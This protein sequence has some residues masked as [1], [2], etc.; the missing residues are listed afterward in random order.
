MGGC[1]R[2][3]VNDAEP[4][5][6]CFINRFRF[7]VASSAAV[8]VLSCGRGG[9][10][11]PEDVP[12][13]AVI[14]ENPHFQRGI[15][16]FPI[17]NPLSARPNQTTN[18]DRMLSTGAEWVALGAVWYQDNYK[19]TLIAPD[20]R[21]TASD[22][23]VREV[24]RY[25]HGKGAKVMLKPCVNSKD[26]TWRA[27]FE[28][29]SVDAWFNSYRRFINHYADIA[30]EENVEMLCVGVEYKWSDADMYDRW[31]DVVSAVRSHYSGELT[32]AADWSN[33][34]SVCF[35]DL[36]DYVGIDAYFPISKEDGAGLSTLARGWKGPLDGVESWLYTARLADKEVLFTEVGYQ[37]RPACWKTPAI[38]KNE[39]V[40]TRAQELCYKA[41]FMT[42][43]ARPWLRGIY[44]WRW[45]RGSAD[46]GGGPQNNQWTPKRKPAGKVLSDYY[47]SY[48]SAR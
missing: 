33:Y 48:P 6:S 3:D 42:A 38:T 11:N 17:K 9:A 14:P 12:Y 19:S 15:T 34:R 35:W 29:T 43:P 32:Y 20:P 30:A 45:D 7:L 23:S 31:A 13:K 2:P 16:Y 36:V 47:N 40:D 24:I 18:I 39:R 44:I 25:L 46:G 21:K 1:P 37:S 27:N 8:I 41:L 22:E 10:F 26:G 5:R 4:G 28:P